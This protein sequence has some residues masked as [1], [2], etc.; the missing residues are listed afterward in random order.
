MGPRRLLRG[1]GLA[2]PGQAPDGGD[3]LIRALDGDVVAR[4]PHHVEARVGH[5]G[6]QLALRL[7]GDGAVGGAGEHED[8]RVHL[9][10]RAA[11]VGPGAHGLGGQRHALGVTALA[12]RAGDAGPAVLAYNCK[13]CFTV[14][15]WFC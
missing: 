4:L 10:Q 13:P 1:D 12:E 14:L 5:P 9:R 11:D 7:G 3:E 15:F 8:R 2:A 6:R